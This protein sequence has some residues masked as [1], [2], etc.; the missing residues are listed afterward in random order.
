MSDSQSGDPAGVSEAVSHALGLLIV[1]AAASFGLTVASVAAT[2]LVAE[3]HAHSIAHLSLPALMG[4]VVV[5]RCIQLVRR[6]GAARDD[7]WNRAQAVDSFDSRL[8]RILS[9]VVPLAWFVGG[10]SILVRHVPGFHDLL[11]GPG[12]LLPL[13]AALWVLATFA[14]MDA[15]RDLIAAGLAESDRRF[16]DYWRNIGTPR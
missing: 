13:G 8:A 12:L 5:L 7:A 9:I 15:C 2:A 10:V 6:R 4:V 14:W 16:R 1:G 11:A 3:G